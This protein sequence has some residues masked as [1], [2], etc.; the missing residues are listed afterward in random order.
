MEANEIDTSSLSLATVRY[1]NKERNGVEF[2]DI[3]AY[4]LLINV[5]GKLYNYF[6]LD[7]NLL[8]FRRSVYSNVT[9]DGTSFGTKL[10]Y[11]SGNLDSGVCY[12][13][14]RTDMKS[15]LKSDKASNRQIEDYVIKSSNYFI[16]REEIM[17]RRRFS[18]FQRDKIENIIAQ[19]EKN[20][21][22][23]DKYMES[24]SKEYQYKK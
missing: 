15:V 14:D 18:R 16:D 23:F 4:V 11:V 20:K 5:N 8:V 17:K 2:T 10:R 21:R 3:N 22:V 12:I 6:T 13:L 24:A 7:N 9:S 19:D 1:F